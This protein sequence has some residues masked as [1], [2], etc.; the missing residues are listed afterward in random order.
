MRLIADFAPDVIHIHHEFGIGISGILAAKI[1]KLP[2]VYTLHTMYDQYVYYVAPRPL[3]PVVTKFSHAYNRFI[4]DRANVLT[5]PSI[6]CEEYF[7]RI[8]VQKA[9]NLIPNAID[10]E[11]FDPGRFSEG[12]KADFKRKYGIPED[13]TLAV[14][15]GRLGKEKSVDV[16]LE[17]W[18]QTITPKD[19]LHLVIVGEGPDKKALELLAEGLNIKDMVT[20][21]GLIKH[22]AIPECFASC[23]IYA[24]ASLSDTNSISML[25][26]MASGLPALERYDEANAGQLGQIE[27]GVNGYS[28][29]TAE[30]MALRMREIRDLTGE[31]RQAL[32]DAVIAS[33]VSR[34][35]T[36]LANYMLEVYDKARKT[37]NSLK[38]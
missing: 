37:R 32:K 10:L 12:Q 9:M 29:T 2:L 11:A 36:A 19:G 35:A 3:Q 1:H 25:E 4:A 13:K 6:K 17:Y 22:E 21:T 27:N 23:D 5:G 20:F 18:A 7:R 31:A 26:G 8:G 24:T 14:F 15:V 28:F 16:L 30:E 33:M 34:G 38:G